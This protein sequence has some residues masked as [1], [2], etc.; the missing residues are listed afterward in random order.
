MARSSRRRSTAGADELPG[1][2]IPRA[3]A[4]EAMV[5]AVNIP[6]QEPS[7]GQALCS[8]RES[9]SSLSASMAWAP[10]A[11]KTLVMSS[12]RSSTRPGKIVPP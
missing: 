11:S 9:S 6:A 7:V 4:T 3:S 5:L 8:I 12:A 1:R 10:T 2:D